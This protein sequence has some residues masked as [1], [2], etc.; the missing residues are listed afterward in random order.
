MSS[1]KRFKV[2]CVTCCAT[3]NNNYKKTHELKIQNGSSVRIKVI[4][5]MSNPFKIAA[6]KIKKRLV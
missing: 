6:K 1:H 4:F 5:A 3:F 2:K